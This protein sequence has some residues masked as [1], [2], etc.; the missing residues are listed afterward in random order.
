M[1]YFN[2]YLSEGQLI[3]HY[4]EKKNIDFTFCID[5]REFSGSGYPQDLP[6]SFQSP[7]NGHLIEFRV[8]GS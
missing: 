7:T 6:V 3:H 5:L 1:F 2:L 4:Y 8:N